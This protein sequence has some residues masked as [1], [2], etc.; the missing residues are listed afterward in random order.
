MA[1]ASWGANLIERHMVV[2]DDALDMMNEL[3]MA[4]AKRSYKL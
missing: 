2:M 1:S 3:A 4:L